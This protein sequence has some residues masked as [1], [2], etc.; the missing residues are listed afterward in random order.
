MP[1]HTIY[2]LL[3]ELHSAIRAVRTE[4][5]VANSTVDHLEQTFNKLATAFRTENDK[6]QLS[7]DEAV[8]RLDAEIQRLMAPFNE[9]LSNS[10]AS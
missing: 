1:S 9:R 8:Q 7:S 10:S 2:E 5:C 4:L 3:D 6:L